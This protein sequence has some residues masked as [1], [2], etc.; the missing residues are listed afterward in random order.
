MLA[1]DYRLDPAAAAR[2]KGVDLAAADATALRYRLFPGDIVLRG[3]G[4]DFSTRWGWVQV[5]DFA[6]GLQAVVQEL[7][8]DGE[9]RFEFT[10]SNAALLFRLENGEV[11][12]S[13]TYAPGRLRVPF[14]EFCEDVRRFA[15]RVRAATGATAL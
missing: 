14:P 3:E 11:A 8:R 9:A 4:A 15:Q 13:S 12:I 1:L 10:E 2:A 6:L 7:E 5:L